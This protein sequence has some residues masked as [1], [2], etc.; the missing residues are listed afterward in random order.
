MIR[1]A[2]INFFNANSEK[3]AMLDFFLE[4]CLR[5][6]NLYA[7]ELW[8]SGYDEKWIDFVVD[9]TSWLG[10][11]LQCKLG[12]DVLTRI[13]T[14]RKRGGSKPVL[15]K[16]SVLLFDS[17]NDTK[18][19]GSGKFDIWVRLKSL[20]TKG[21]RISINLPAKSHRHLIKYLDDSI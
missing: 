16:K 6:K 14:S 4:E 19:D 21:S 20:G 15:T 7:D 2:T 3:L 5:I 18:F 12:D 13:K 1:T 9:E 8:N 11:R 10:L 17:W